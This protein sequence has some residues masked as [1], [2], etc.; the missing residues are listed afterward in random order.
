MGATCCYIHGDVVG[1][2]A[3]CKHII[4]N[5]EKG[6]N[7]KCIEI[8]VRALPGNATSEIET[9]AGPYV[10]HIPFCLQC[11]EDYRMSEKMKIIDDSDNIKRATLDFN[12]EYGCALCIERYALENKIK[13]VK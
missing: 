11:F 6:L 5:I 12:V 13:H 10:T 1:I 8:I 7:E 4:D 3:A 2:N 9:K